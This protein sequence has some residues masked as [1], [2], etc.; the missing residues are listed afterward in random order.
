MIE[1]WLLVQRTYSAFH[2]EQTCATFLRHGIPLRKTRLYFVRYRRKVARNSICI[3]LRSRRVS[4]LPF[5]C[6]TKKTNAPG[7][8]GLNGGGKERWTHALS[9]EGSAGSFR[10]VRNQF[11]GMTNK[12]IVSSRLGRSPVDRQMRLSIDRTDIRR[13]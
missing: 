13:W 6:R 5:P 9:H 1:T 10:V 7:I 3:E 8:K 11:I 12:N 4:I 2:G